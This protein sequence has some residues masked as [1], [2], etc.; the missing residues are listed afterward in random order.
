MKL[1]VVL[2]MSML[3]ILLFS[4]K[5]NSV[6]ND[7]E[8]PVI[9]SGVIKN[10]GITNYQYG[11]H[12]LIDDISQIIYALKSDSI[13]LDLYINNKVKVYGHL[14]DGYPLNDGPELL[15]VMKIK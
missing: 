4:C 5:E 6:V 13:N 2:I 12:I 1:N 15:N 11:S 3:I 14:V 9:A 10:M 8:F 7:I